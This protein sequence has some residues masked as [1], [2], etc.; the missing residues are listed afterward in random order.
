[1]GQLRYYMNCEREKSSG[2]DSLLMAEFGMCAAFERA[3]IVD[4]NGSPTYG[5][6]I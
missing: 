2:D 3:A 6:P 5:E 4:R 1:M